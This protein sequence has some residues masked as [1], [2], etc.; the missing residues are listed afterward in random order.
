MHVRTIFS[1]GTEASDIELAKF[2]LLWQL[3]V[4]T[5][6]AMLPLK[7]HIKN[8][9]LQILQPNAKASIYV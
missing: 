5:E 4:M 7:A 9:Q 1:P 3:N 2:F 8:K 6:V